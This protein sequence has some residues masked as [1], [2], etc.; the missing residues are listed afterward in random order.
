MFY[1]NFLI[2]RLRRVLNSYK[3]TMN[4]IGPEHSIFPETKTFHNQYNELNEIVG[5]EEFAL[6]DQESSGTA[7]FFA[8]TGPII[9]ALEYGDVLVVDELDSKIH[10]NLVSKLVELFNSAKT[11]PNNAQLI[12]NSHDTN[13]LG[14]GLFRRDQIWF[15]EKDRYGAAVL[16]SLASFKTDEGGRKSDNFEEKYISG[17]YGAIPVLGD[18]ATLFSDQPANGK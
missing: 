5:V 13:L 15:V 9:K 14:S 11:N 6:D 3:R 4:E 7:K 1:S 18:F 12:F 2:T 8:L 10:P 16:Y 17:R